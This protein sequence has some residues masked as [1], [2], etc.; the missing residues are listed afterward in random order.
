[1]NSITIKAPAKVNLFL[2]VVSRRPDGYHTIETLFEKIALFDTIRLKKVS[3]GISISSSEKGLP[4]ERENLAYKAASL[5]CEKYGVTSG[6][7]IDIEK[8]IPIAA[9]LGGGSSNAAAVL[10]GLN[11]LWNVGLLPGELATLGKRLG[12]DIPFFISKEI[13]AVG[14]DRGDRI[15]GVDT[16]MKLWHILVIPPFPILSRDA[17][18]WVDRTEKKASLIDDALSAVSK[19][20]IGL[21]GRSLHND[22]EDILFE[23]LKAL[24]ECRNRLVEY[25]A[26]GAMISGSGPALFGIVRQKKEV[27]KV[28]RKIEKHL[29]TKDKRWQVHIVPTLN[30]EQGGRKDD[31]NHRSKDITKRRK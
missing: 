4:S 25:G 5:L 6:V 21:L 1:M 30:D 9:G 27:V 17:Y 11:R 31:G 29:A 14:R 13:W 16:K 20:D 2:K 22:F 23:R 12:A 24:E 15:E 19:R 10:I 3:K 26:E 18:E 7:K 8:L 28:K